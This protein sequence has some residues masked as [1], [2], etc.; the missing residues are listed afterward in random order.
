MAFTCVYRYN[1]S[2]Q[3]RL[4]HGNICGA[5]TFPG[6]ETVETA[7]RD[8]ITGDVSIKVT[9]Q[10]MEQADPY[11]PKHGGTKDPRDNSTIVTNVTDQLDKKVLILQDRVEAL[12]D[13]L[14]T[15]SDP[16]VDEKV[17]DSDE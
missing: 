7:V 16:I 8:P 13:R 2:E 14:S 10:L 12:E 17:N 15:P 9:E 6:F 5:P 4:K 1:P 11:C 3:Y